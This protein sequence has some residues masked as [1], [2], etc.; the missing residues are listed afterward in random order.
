MGCSSF[1]AFVQPVA[2]QSI[3]V[4]DTI[5]IISPSS[6]ILSISHSLILSHHPLPHRHYGNSLF[7][8][9]LIISNQQALPVLVRFGIL[10][11]WRHLPVF[12]HLVSDTV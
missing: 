11:Q 6:A 2:A 1:V 9:L 10:H 12:G 8:A 5:A 4:G 7:R 3:A